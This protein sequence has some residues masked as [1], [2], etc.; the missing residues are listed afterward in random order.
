M[1]KVQI[2]QSDEEKHSLSQDMARILSEGNLIDTLVECTC[3]DGQEPIYVHS[4]FIKTRSKKLGSKL[5]D[6]Q[7]EKNKV[8]LYK[9]SVNTWSRWYSWSL[10]TPNMYSNK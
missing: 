4:L 8:G 10:H 1:V 3:T 6:F 7:D 9:I 2:I 5:R